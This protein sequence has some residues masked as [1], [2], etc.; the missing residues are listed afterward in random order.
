MALEDRDE[1][2]AFANSAVKAKI[3]ELENEVLRL[4]ILSNRHEQ[5]Y[6]REYKMRGELLS[7]LG[8]FLPG[9]SDVREGLTRLT[10]R[11]TEA[12]AKAQVALDLHGALGVRW[13]DDPYLRIQELK[14]FED[15]ALALVATNK[16][17]QAAWNQWLDLRKRARNSTSGAEQDALLEEAAEIAQK[18]NF[19]GALLAQVES[20]KGKLEQR[21]DEAKALLE[22]CPRACW[23][24][25][26]I[27]VFAILTA[28]NEED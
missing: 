23:S 20:K 9:G 28:G 10:A 25:T 18:W 6:F 13:G 7:I 15:Q 14:A 1:R 5:E 26:D 2:Q 24:K 8:D 19:L 12:E 17:K 3:A 11:L 16:E 22:L 21:I 27:E 4:Q